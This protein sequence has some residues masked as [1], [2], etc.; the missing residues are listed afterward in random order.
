MAA[1]GEREKTAM[2]SP[3]LLTLVKNLP[4]NSQPAE[5]P[6]FARCF[7]KNYAY[8]QFGRAQAA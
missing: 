1:V 6:R 3:H 8:I 2:H 4:L 5:P 7:S